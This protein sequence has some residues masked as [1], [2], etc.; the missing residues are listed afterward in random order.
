M[1]ILMISKALIVGQYQTKPL[2]L[3]R[4]P[5]V[6]L[7]VVVPPVWRDER[8]MMPLE[9]KHVDGYQ[10][11]VAPL[12]L[13]GHYHLNYFPS[14]GDIIERV[15]PDLIHL[16]EEPYNFATF[17][18]L[19]AARRFLPRP[20]TLFFTWQNLK[21]TYP[22]P[23]SW[24]E[25]YTL[26]KTDYAIAGNPSAVQ[27]LRSKGFV[28]PIRVIPQFGVDP[29]FFQPDPTRHR[30][31]KFVVGFAARLVPEKGAALLL[32]ALKRL[33]EDW[34]L[35]IV[36]SGPELAKLESSAR[37]LGIADRVH[38]LPWQPSA[39]MPDFFRALDVLV[40]PSLSRPGWTE[41]FGRVLVEAMACGIPVIGSN[42][43]EIP[44]V[45]GDAGL[46]FPE[47]DVDAL[48]LALRNLKEDQAR[49]DDLSARGRAR[50]LERFTQDQIVDETYAAYEE[51]VK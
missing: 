38:F 15:K 44:N 30:D 12:C 33:Q 31:A 28:K 4:K 25:A 5:G 20:R 47:G 29:T 40:A 21:Q 8:G 50:V 10:F 19:L 16:D 32:T 9:T 37:R 24:I 26:A 51:L 34:E 2:G 23:F 27:V 13:N 46:I 3:A 49:R 6:Q 18:A 1:R 39:Q 42:C 11:I 45:I 41:Q 14:I 17:H 43:G 48:A 22:P 35:R 7:T 36:G